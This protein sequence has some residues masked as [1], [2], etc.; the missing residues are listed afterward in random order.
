MGK[1]NS[2][3]DEHGRI[4]ATHVTECE[5][6]EDLRRIEE[7]FR[8]TFEQAAVGAVHIALDG[9]VLRANERL[10]RM[11][12]YG[13]CSEL[14]GRRM[15]EHIHPDDLDED[16]RQ[17][18]RLRAGE[19]D[20][21]SA[22][23]KYRRLDGAWLWA[24][25]TI[26]LVRDE[27]GEPDCYLAVV[28]DISDQVEAEERLAE[29]EELFRLTFEQAAVGMAQVGRP[30]RPFQRVNTRFCEIVGY[31]REELL[32]LTP[33]DITHPDDADTDMRQADDVWQRGAASASAEK[34]Y[35][36][37]DGSYVWVERTL[38]A[39]RD[40]AGTPTRFLIVVE[41]ITERIEAERRLRAAEEHFRLLFH[42]ANEAI[43]VY[44]VLRDEK[45]DL[46]D[47]CVD[48]LNSAQLEQMPGIPRESIVGHRLSELYGSAEAMRPYFDM[49]EDILREGKPKRYELY[50]Q[51][52][53]RHVV[54]SV[55]PLEPDVWASMT[56][57]VT[58]QR[59]AQEE[60][61]KRDEEI[62]QAYED[63]L[64]AVTGG[65]L[66][67]VTVDEM[68]KELGKPLTPELVI[69]S[70]EGLAD[71]RGR[72][73]SA[74]R[75]VYPELADSMKVLNPLGEALN[76]AL[77]HAG[78]GTYRVYRRGD[79]VQIEVTDNGP[80]ID[81]RSLPHSTLV[82][83]FS[84]TSTLGVG[85]TIMLQLADRVLLATQPG[86]TSVVLEIEAS[87]SA[88]DQDPVH[89]EDARVPHRV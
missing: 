27:S 87:E 7:R 69:A 44:R 47:V 78:G 19:I 1:Y 82:P 35:V 12:G 88:E 51:P 46:A 34:R 3:T 33:R 42:N 4:G 77:K 8:N 20:T 21:Y 54:S 73:R 24:H 67:L 60:L 25:S 72:V 89:A 58:D 63:V 36:R 61:K 84:T 18:E 13:H 49:A 10:C 48:D 83:G 32:R 26:S 50:F 43:A 71:A 80:G 2:S 76:N 55:Y 59:R 17:M 40:A 28:L 11:L 16:R 45:G 14:T 53:D 74:L 29:S 30:D 6:D 79:T 38:S 85:F 86:G 15:Q 65:K 57:D 37:A 39:V 56:M 5:R 81:F 52:A 70:P 75:E 66:A 41:D 9:S 64:D 23:R 68:E 62:R 22:R 31:S